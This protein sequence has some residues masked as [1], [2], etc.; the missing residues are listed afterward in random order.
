MP[1]TTTVSMLRN[2][3]EQGFAV[4]AFNVENMEMAQAIIS[5]AEELRA[6]VILQTTPSTVRYAGTGMYAAMVAALAQEASVPV[7]MHLDHGDSFALCAQA[8]R[9]GYT[10]V[11]IDGSKGEHRL[12]LQSQR[13]VRR[14]GC[15]RGRGDWP[16]GRQGGRF[17][18]RRRLHHPRG[19][20]AL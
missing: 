4:G 3:Q 14:R 20:R 2:A 15:P 17:G 5:A 11:M 6:P 1:L 12:N 9:S 7:A 18:I 19:G 16:C 13:D 10:S 8:L